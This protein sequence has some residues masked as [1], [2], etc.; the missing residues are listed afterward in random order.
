MATKKATTAAKK[1][2]QVIEK[3]K[4]ENLEVVAFA[5]GVYQSRTVNPGDR[6]VLISKDHFDPKFMEWVMPFPET[7]VKEEVQKLPPEEVEKF[8]KDGL[9]I[10]PE[11]A[12]NAG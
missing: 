9:G 12:E 10:E 6:F 5:R 11:G 2:K 8:L 7:A 1:T 3:I 4:Q